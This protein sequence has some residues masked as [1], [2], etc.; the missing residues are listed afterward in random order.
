MHGRVVAVSSRLRANRLST[1]TQTDKS[2]AKEKYGTGSSHLNSILRCRVQFDLVQGLS[3]DT[4]EALYFV[5]FGV[6]SWI[7]LHWAKKSIHEATRKIMK[8]VPIS[9]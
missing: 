3:N 2:N 9:F 7:V 4:Y 5:Q 6:V 8:R 1:R